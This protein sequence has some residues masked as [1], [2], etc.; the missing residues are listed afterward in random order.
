MLNLLYKNV[1]TLL[2]PFEKDVLL[3]SMRPKALYFLTQK[4]K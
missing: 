4:V 3:M 1:C 2:Q